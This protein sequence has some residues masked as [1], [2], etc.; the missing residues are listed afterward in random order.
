MAELVDLMSNLNLSSTEEKT[1][2]D[3]KEV[4]VE[5]PVQ[6]IVKIK[7]PKDVIQEKVEEATEEKNAK[8]KE[9]FEKC[10]KGY[11]LINDDPI[12][13]SPWEDINAQILNAAGY[14]VQYKSSGSHNSGKDLECSLGTFSNKSILYDTSKNT[15][16]LSSYRLTKVCS[17]KDN[18]TMDNIINEINNRKNFTHY[19]IIVREEKEKKIKYDWY[20][21]PSDYSALNPNTYEWSL[22]TG[23][24]GK[25]KGIPVG[26]QTNTIDGSSMSITFSMSSQLWIEIAITD[27]LKKHIIATCD[28]DVGRKMNYIDLY[29]KS[30]NLPVISPESV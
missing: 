25:N 19:S 18:G 6:R 8:L 17:D 9:F 27:E 16:Q 26:W 28:I 10:V 22:K 5:K 15:F 29:E 13:E 21:I 12:K 23:Q 11:H 14:T 2:E 30:T 20:L 4:A 24:K 3:K 1:V 7:K